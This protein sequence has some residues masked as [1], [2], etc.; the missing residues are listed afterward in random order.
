MKKVVFAL[1]AGAAFAGAAQAQQTLKVDD[2]PRVYV[3]VGVSTADHQYK[4]ANVI[5]HDSYKASGK[6]FGGYEF[7]N[8]YG[9]EV[10]YT[11]FGSSDYTRVTPTGTVRNSGDGNA[12]YVAAKFNKP[13]NSWL[14]AYGKL[15]VQNARRYATGLGST[16]DTGVYA[17]AGL[18]WNI[19]KNV[20][21]IAEYERYGK[22]AQFGAQS[23]VWTIGARY[24]F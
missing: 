11:D 10:G 8:T 6:V 18:Q 21:I 3:G 23:D 14:A 15:G 4:S 19:N 12:Y 5:D 13:L 9:V 22:D 2:N 7:N 20:G 16:S 1:I 17:A 24:S